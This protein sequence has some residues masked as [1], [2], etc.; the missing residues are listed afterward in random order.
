MKIDLTKLIYN[1]LYKIPVEGE[2]IIPDEFLEGTEIREISAVKVSG[3]VFNNEEEFE[4]NINITGTM[5][6]PCARTLK[7]VNY[8]FNIDINE[9]I[10]ENDDN[11]LE[12][13][14]NSLEIFPIIWQ[15]ILVDVPLRVLAPDAKEESLEGDG[16]RL[17]TQDEAKEEIDPRLAKLKD[18]IKE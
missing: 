12:I 11:S 15:N 1:N 13:I 4:L 3:F 6:L 7:D 8:P 5:V 10:G 18:Y 14:Q 17:I 9:I 2:V 16:W